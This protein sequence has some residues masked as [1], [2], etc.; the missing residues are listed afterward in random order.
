MPQMSRPTRWTECQWKTFI[1]RS[2]SSVHTN[3]RR[4]RHFEPLGFLHHFAEQTFSRRAL[5]IPFHQR[6][7]LDLGEFIGLVRRVRST[8]SWFIL[9]VYSTNTRHSPGH[10]RASRLSRCPH[11]RRCRHS[12]CF[13][14]HVAVVPG[15]ITRL[16]RHVYRLHR[17]AL[18]AAI[19]SDSGNPLPPGMV[20]SVALFHIIP[21]PISIIK[22][23][24]AQWLCSMFASV[25]PKFESLLCMRNT[26]PFFC[27]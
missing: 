14:P 19:F 23:N 12:G 2:L 15:S 21:D 24:L 27:F 4:A 26:P 3:T 7:T 16:R 17:A 18:H 22:L 10:V 20:N 9:P 25:R 11:R 6:L 8:F 13:Q 5:H 1:S